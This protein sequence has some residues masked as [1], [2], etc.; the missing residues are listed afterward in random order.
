MYESETK[1]TPRMG[2]VPLA[3]G[4]I[5]ALFLFRLWY[6]SRFELVGDEAYYWYCSKHLDWSYFDKGP[7]AAWTIA[8]GTWLFGDSVFGVRFFSVLL[9]AVTAASLFGLARMLF[10]AQVAF[11]AVLVSAVV[12]MFAVGGVLMTIDP[13]SVFFWTA[14]AITFWKAKD[15]ARFAPWLAT[16]ALVGIGMLAKYTNIA[17]LISFAIFCAWCP[18]Y[19]RSFRRPHFY[20][21]AMAAVIFV[22]PV[23][24]W[25]YRHDWVTVVHLLHRGAVDSHW[26]FSPSELFAFLGGQAGVISPLL[27]LGVFAAAGWPGMESSRRVEMR[28]L[29]ALFWPLVLFYSILSVNKAGQ[30][31]WIA[32]SYVAGIIL[33]AAGWTAA[34]KKRHWVRPLAVCAIAIAAIETILLHNTYWL[35]LPRGRD[36]FDRARGFASIADKAD[37]IASAQGARFFISNKYSLA[38]LL[39]FYLP[40]HPD[41]YRPPADHIQDQFS[42][43][44]GYAQKFDTGSALYVADSPRIPRS[45]RRDFANVTLL[46]ESY[47]RYRD[48][49]I[50]KYYFFLCSDLRHAATT[51]PAI[52]LPHANQP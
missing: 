14:A 1:T 5:L 30:P 25:N 21:M 28:F 32:P 4:L 29:R 33:L 45:L 38:S 47:S 7:G 2:Y 24:V 20:A 13:L 37:R 42:I 41:T 48:R 17:E 19:R 43:W 9:S 35:H 27:F 50:L 36:P 51:P 34:E 23:I 44:P 11:R 52:P 12:P 49:E 10:S 26:K 16:G 40:G 18:E 15:S 46:E 8:L 3:A 39:A 22:L 6:C 31:N